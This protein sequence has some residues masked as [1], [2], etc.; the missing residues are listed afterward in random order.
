MAF[1]LGT[2][3]TFVGMRMLEDQ[4]FLWSLTIGGGV[5]AFIL[6]LHPL[7]GPV[8][9]LEKD[10]IRLKEEGRCREFQASEVTGYRI[11]RITSL[12]LRLF[13]KNGESIVHPL[14]CNVSLE[15][16]EH[17]LRQHGFWTLVDPAPGK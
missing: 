11:E 1:A 17:E 5:T 6:L 12:K 13:L 15:G 10:L 14:D 8:I 4:P 2:V 3:G 9:E 16:L 7:R